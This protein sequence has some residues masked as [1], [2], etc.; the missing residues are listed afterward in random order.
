MPSLP[1]FALAEEDR[2]A[3][4]QFARHSVQASVT[5]SP[6]GSSPKEEIFARV[7]GVFVTVFIGGKLRGCIGVVE[8]EKP[9]DESIAHCASSAAL[10]DPRFPPIRAEELD[11]LQIE[12]SLLSQ[13]API[14]PDEIE[15]G[16]H[17]LLIVKDRQR[18][19][20]LPQVAIEHR[21]DRESFL[22]ETCRKAGLSRDAWKSGS[23]QILGFT[24][25]V[26][27]DRSETHAAK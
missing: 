22:A 25:E 27:S 8:A 2:R 7:C 10:H 23:V 6:S 24:C 4:L 9:L 18:G 1:D 21:L 20:L 12:V 13:P 14:Q 15:L 19:L 17:G 11:R 5:R 3:L 16:R 26:F